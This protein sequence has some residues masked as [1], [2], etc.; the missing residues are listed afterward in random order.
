MG[1]EAFQSYMTE[2]TNP[3]PAEQREHREAEEARMRDFLSGLMTFPPGTSIPENFDGMWEKLLK[4][5]FEREREWRFAK[6]E[7]KKLDRVLKRGWATPDTTAL[8]LAFTVDRPASELHPIPVVLCNDDG[9]WTPPIDLI[10]VVKTHP[11][12]RWVNEGLGELSHQERIKRRLKWAKSL[13]GNERYATIL[14]QRAEGLDLS[15]E[16]Q[17]HSDTPGAI[18]IYRIKGN[19]QFWE[20]VEAA[21]QFGRRWALWEVYGDGTVEEMIQKG[22]L[23]PSGKAPDAWGREV[24]RLIAEFRSES[25]EKPTPVRLLKWIGGTQGNNAKAPLKLPADSRGESLI[26]ISWDEFKNRVK[27]VKQ[28][29]L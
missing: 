17:Y 21:I 4:S 23:G 28:R 2:L 10:W 15:M 16:E 20:I 24:E 3:E 6:I 27:A 8:S 11:Y 9:H 14:A 18:E 22:L 5:I 13:G 12:I 29:A 1:E 7:T 26:G 25:P 19:E